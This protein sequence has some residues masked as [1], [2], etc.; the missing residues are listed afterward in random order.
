MNAVACHTIGSGITRRANAASKRA[1]PTGKAT[2][3]ITVTESEPTPATCR[4]R[5]P[6]TGAATRYPAANIPLGPSMSRRA[7]G[8]S[9]I[10]ASVRHV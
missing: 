10:S 2:I 9:E 6:M 5:P 4:S 8:V 3:S 7:R 1:I